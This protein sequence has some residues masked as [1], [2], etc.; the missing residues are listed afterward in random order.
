MPDLKDRLKD[1]F[2][3][4]D[5]DE[6]QDYELYDPETGQYTQRKQNM[7]SARG[8]RGRGGPQRGQP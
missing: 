2:E 5:S 1:V 6:E 3:N 4:K 7:K 8:P